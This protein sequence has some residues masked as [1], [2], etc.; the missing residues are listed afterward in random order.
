MYN[1]SC[2]MFFQSYLIITSTPHIRALAS[3]YIGT[4]YEFAFVK[5][6]YGEDQVDTSPVK[7]QHDFCCCHYDH[8]LVCFVK[9]DMASVL[10]RECW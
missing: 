9:V 4:S 6:K 7:F 1:S 10:N 8:P 3:S 5:Y 2:A